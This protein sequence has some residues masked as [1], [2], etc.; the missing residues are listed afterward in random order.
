MH[1]KKLSSLCTQWHYFFRMSFDANGCGWK[2]AAK[3][4]S[5]SID[6]NLSFST[7]RHQ[8]IPTE[9]CLK[10]N[11]KVL[12][13]LWDEKSRL[14]LKHRWLELIVQSVGD[15]AAAAVVVVAVFAFVHLFRA[16]CHDTICLL[17]IPCKQ[18]PSRF[19]TIVSVSHLNHSTIFS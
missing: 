9:Y 6:Y 14:S 12:I 16:D 3:T 7:N 1:T 2:S 13:L 11:H 18:Q 19:E 10:K 5:Q 8:S 4:C 17:Q 15:A